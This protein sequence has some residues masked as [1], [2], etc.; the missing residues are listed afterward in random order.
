MPKKSTLNKKLFKWNG[1][2]GLPEFG[3][4]EDQDFELAFNTA[5]KMN[6]EE[7]DA[8]AANKARPTF[9][10]TIIALEKAG[11]EISRVS[12]IFWNKSGAHTNPDIQ[13][14]E[15]KIAPKMSRHSS[16]IYMNKKLFARID[17]LWQD[18][19][20]LKLDD[21][22][23]IVL[24]R[25]WKAYVKSGAKL[26]GV[27]QKRLARI[28]E[29]LAELG[30]N[31][32]QNML[33]DEAAWAMFISDEKQLE[34][35]PDFLKSAMAAA[36]KE[37][38]KE[39]KFAI[40]LSRSIYEPFMSF[41]SNRDLREKTLKAF[42]SRGKNKGEH[43]NR[44][45]VTQTLTLR[46]EKAKLLGYENYAQLKLDNTMAKTP[47]AVNELLGDVWQKALAKTEQ[48]E[49]ALAE[50]IAKDGKNHIVE[51]WD[52]R[53]YSEKL[54]EEKYD[55]SEAELKPYLQLENV[56]AACF[57]VAQRLFN[58]TLE[59]HKNVEAYH[60]EVRTFSVK[61]AKG[62]NKGQV[63]G[64][65]LGD[66]FARPS[67]RSGAWM[68]AF[69]SQHKLGKKE[70]LPIIYNVMNFAKGEPAL[71][72]LTD[73]RTLF[74]EFGH[75]LHGLLSNVTHPSVAGTAVSRDWVELPS[76]LFEHWFM[77]PEILT[78]YAKHYKTQKPIPKTLLKKLKAAD[79]FNSGFETIEFTSSALIDMAFH[80]SEDIKD[81][82]AF[83][84]KTLK[85]LN[86]PNAIVMRHATPHFAHIFAGD[87]YSAGYYSY[88]WSE[89]L[90][91]DAFRAFEEI[92][93]PFDKKLA[94]RLEKYIYSSGGS[95]PPETAYKKFRGQMPTTQAML[96]GRGLS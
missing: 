39:G 5:M 7:I 6:L 9:K 48:E 92:K 36:A 25:Y 42:I 3:K 95:L 29:Q 50:L 37:R 86:L 61:I 33:A 28:N 46:N 43:D 65:F 22:Q 31:F 44:P 87:G 72:S 19:E 18:K 4:I 45:I 47:E 12:A 17:A 15:R 68:S 10:N 30:A 78:K 73:A 49:K 52:W 66:Y 58:I 14:L 2:L 84:R 74:H 41:S 90:D 35:L 71:L 89:I 81:P 62:K 13:A 88:L 70:Q 40:T 67:K 11:L 82:I 1:P 76:Q 80:T 26:S 94:K 75:A 51:P 69:Q 85:K 8:L 20:S 32:G 24:E 38:G 59:E 16:K 79:T 96:D 53:Y 57:D 27:K 93:D 56:I 54:R 63:I 60:P 91:A 64:A 23:N 83:E 21:E 34:G 77:V 55:F